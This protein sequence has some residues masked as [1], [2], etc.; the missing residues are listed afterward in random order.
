MQA[1]LLAQFCRLSTA[2]KLQL[3]GIR[4]LSYIHRMVCLSLISIGDPGASEAGN[5]LNIYVLCVL[6]YADKYFGNFKPIY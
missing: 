1:K 3:F 4:I 5:V 6:I 2:K